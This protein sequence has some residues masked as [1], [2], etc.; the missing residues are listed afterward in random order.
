MRPCGGSMGMDEKR[1]APAG[2]EANLR[3][4]TNDSNSD[5]ARRA[6]TERGYRAA[7]RKHARRAE[8]WAP[9]FDPYPRPVLRNSPEAVLWTVLHFDSI[10]I[11]GM[12]HPD[13]LREAWGMYPEHREAIERT[14]RGNVA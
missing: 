3:V 2:T 14:G 1:K 12:F 8:S 4:A 10:G 7:G 11:I 9:D 5:L 13:A 6:E